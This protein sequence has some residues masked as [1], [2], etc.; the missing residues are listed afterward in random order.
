MPMV[1]EYVGVAGAAA[2]TTFNVR[3]G[4]DAGTFTFNGT[5]AARIYGGALASSLIIIEYMG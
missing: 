1:A 5:G 4:G 2:S 3:A